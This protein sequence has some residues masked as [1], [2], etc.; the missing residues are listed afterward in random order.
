MVS[1]TDTDAPFFVVVVVVLALKKD[2][3]GGTV[4]YGTIR[5]DIRQHVSNAT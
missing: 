1:K 3:K 4:R 5:Y 2:K